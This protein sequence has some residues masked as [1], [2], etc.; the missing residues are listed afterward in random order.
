MNTWS[1]VYANNNEAIMT[2]EVDIRSLRANLNISQKELANDLELSLDTIKSWEQ[3]RRN[4][5]G[6]ARKILRLIEQYPSL[7]IK[8]KNN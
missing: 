4:P 7:Y 8:F 1:T 2:N 3:G 6:L 5:T